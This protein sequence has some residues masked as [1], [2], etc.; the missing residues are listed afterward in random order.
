M[1][2]TENPLNWLEGFKPG[3]FFLIEFDDKTASD[4]TPEQ[5][6]EIRDVVGQYGFDVQ[7]TGFPKGFY[8][9]LKKRFEK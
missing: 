9:M 2:K 4:R 7:T 8:K 5:L 3:D 1:K 6:N